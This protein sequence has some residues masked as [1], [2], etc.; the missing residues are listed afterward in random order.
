MDDSR[1]VRSRALDVL[2]IVL[3]SVSDPLAV[4]GSKP[5]SLDSMD[6]DL[7]KDEALVKCEY[8]TR[9]DNGS[10]QYRSKLSSW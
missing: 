5:D 1:L 9:E 4:L 10:S 6:M 3:D 8:G 7:S 2:S